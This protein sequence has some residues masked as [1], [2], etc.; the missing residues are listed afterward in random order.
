MN[1]PIWFDTMRL[2]SFIVHNKGSLVIIKFPIKDVFRFQ[3]LKIVLSYV[4]IKWRPYLI[5]VFSVY[6][7]PPANKGLN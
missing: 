7:H 1:S 4:A 5:K 3:S 2:G 6:P